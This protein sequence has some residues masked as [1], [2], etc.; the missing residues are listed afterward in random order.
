MSAVTFFDLILLLMGVVVALELVA[1]RLHLPPA[2]ALIV[3]GVVLALIPGTPD[4]KLDPDLVLVLFL[5]PL[6]MSGA[7]FTVWR[8]FRANLR[9][10]LQ[11]AVGAVAFTTLVVGVVAHYVMPGLPWAACFA[12]GAIVSPPDA[13]AAK[14]VLQNVRLPQRMTVLLEGESL[15][16][17]ASGLVLFRFAVAA[18]LTGMFSVTQ[19][20]ISFVTVAAGGLAAGVAFGFAVT[21]V[22]RRLRDPNLAVIVSLLTAWAAY[23]TADRAQVSGVL[24]VVACGL[25]LGWH[26]HTALSAEM[27]L[28]ARAVWTTVEFVLESMIFILIGLSLRGRHR[29]RG[30]AVPLRVHVSGGL[31]AARA[32]AGAAAARSVSAAGGAD[33]AGLGRH[34]RRG[35]PGRGLVAAGGISRPRFYSGDDVRRH[36]GDGAGAGRHAGA[37]DP[38]AETGQL[39]GGRDDAER[40]GGAGPHGDGADRGG[41]DPVPHAGWHAASPAAAGTIWLP[42]AGGGTV[43]RGGGGFDG[44]SA[45]AF[46]R[47]AG[48]DRGGAR[49]DFAHAP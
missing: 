21:F 34:A 20:A 18:S 1:R 42:G 14:A 23:M 31:P 9:I 37:A 8:D 7:F 19:A 43:R 24:S 32:G 13:V 29:G 4:L 36:H 44:A 6:L 12:L 48:G 46:H 27:R 22:M 16:N 17:D 49:G 30:G 45:R 2:A 10:I 5:P 40:G 39:Y 47:G 3:G 41:A 11:L 33:R 15:V 28:Q 35:E 38:R 26:Q 25:V